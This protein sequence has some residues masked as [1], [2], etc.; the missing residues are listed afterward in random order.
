MNA[1][2]KVALRVTNVS[3][4]FYGS[5]AL[6]QVSIDFYEGEVHIV[7][8]ENGAGKST[9]MKILSGMYMRDE[10]EVEL[11]GKPFN[12]KNPVDAEKLGIVTIYQEFNLSPTITVAENIFLHREPGKVFVDRRKML[13]EAQRYLDMVGCAVDL[14]AKVSRISTANQQMVQIAKALSQNA[15]VLIM[16]EPCSS[17]TEDDTETLFELINQLKKEGMTIIYI[18]H[19]IDNFK[20]IGDRVSVLRDGRMVGMVA[21]ED[22]TKEQIVKMMVGRDID[23]I[24]PK[25]STPQDKVM[26]KIR[27]FNNQKIKDISFEVRKGEVFGLAGLVGAGRSEIVRAIFGMDPKDP[28]SEMFINGN[29]VDVRKPKQAIENGI[30]YIPE[31]RKIMGFVPGRS[32]NF[33]LVLPSFKEMGKGVFVDAKLAKSKADQQR[34]NLEIKALSYNAKVRDLSGGNQQKVVIGKWLMR[35]NIE[36]Y[37]MDEPTR[38]I[39]VGVKMEIYKLINSLA[40]SGKSIILITSEMQELI[41]LCDRIATIAEGKLTKIF[42]REE[43]SQ[44]AILACCV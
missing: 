3:K 41:G 6:N 34:K 12:V 16:D 40:E 44:E 36:L 13:A 21:I 14:N 19:R 32:I 30:A 20:R 17:I 27:N 31:D 39:D 29:I 11:F 33:N 15:K 22:V 43:F 28:G 2:K 37:L 38:G 7:C 9:L 18:D 23:N 35:E 5:Y 10:G 4:L 25:T 26:F 42:E 8:G 24:Y 1:T